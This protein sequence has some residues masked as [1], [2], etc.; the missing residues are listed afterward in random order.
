MLIVLML[1]FADILL[2]TYVHYIT[3]E[4]PSKKEGEEDEV[5]K[6]DEEEDER[7][8]L[9]Q[10]ICKWMSQTKTINKTEELER[11]KQMTKDDIFD[12]A[13]CPD[14]PSSM[15]GQEAREAR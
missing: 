7:L 11:Q 14:E 4:K 15:V 9:Y 10:L 5:E 13:M 2:Q 8:T 3:N 12:L 1:T 6:E